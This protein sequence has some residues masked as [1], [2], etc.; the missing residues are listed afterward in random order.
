MINRDIKTRRGDA[1][2]KCLTPGKGMW[3]KQDMEDTD[4]DIPDDPSLPI[5]YQGRRWRFRISSL[6]TYLLSPYCS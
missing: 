3:L 1:Q 5:C 6:Q 4:W 2:K